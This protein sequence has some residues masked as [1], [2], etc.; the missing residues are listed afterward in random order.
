[1]SKR[2]IIKFECDLFIDTIREH[3]LIWDKAH[4]EHKDKH[5]ISAAW[6]NIAEQFKIG[7]FSAN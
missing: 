3:Q 5:K 7:K 2:S 4:S 6:A 1:M